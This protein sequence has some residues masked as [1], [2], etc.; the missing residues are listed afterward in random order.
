M[1]KSHLRDQL[2]STSFIP[3]IPIVLV[4]VRRTSTCLT[5]R[6]GS[7]TGVPA[8]NVHSNGIITKSRAQLLVPSSVIL[9]TVVN[10]TLA[11][12]TLRFPLIIPQLKQYQK[13][14]LQYQDFVFDRN[15]EGG[16]TS[17]HVPCLTSDGP[18]GNIS[19][20]SFVLLERGVHACT[21][22]CRQ[23]TWK[24]E[25]KT[26]RGQRK[27][28]HSRLCSS[29]LVRVETEFYIISVDFMVHL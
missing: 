26:K 27:M 19:P 8:K 18:F 11:L 14:R 2:T 22:T 12:W 3:N 13:H 9:R 4:R 15:T 16:P 28:W 20:C 6:Q 23:Q 21:G 29:L 17:G 1:V 24:G 10:S 7:R 25:S 5:S